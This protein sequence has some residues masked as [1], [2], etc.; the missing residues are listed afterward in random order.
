MN[1]NRLYELL[2]LVD[3]IRTGNAREFNIAKSELERK[4][5]NDFV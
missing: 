2:A 4:F 3:V 5:K 1:D